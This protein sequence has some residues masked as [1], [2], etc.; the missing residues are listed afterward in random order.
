MSMKSWSEVGFGFPLW[1]KDN[2]EKIKNFI[3][4]NLELIYDEKNDADETRKRF[5]E[6][7]EEEDEDNYGI[8]YLMF[9]ILDEFASETI[10]RIIEK[11]EGE[12][13]FIRGFQPCGDTDTEEHLGVEPI[14][15]WSIKEPVTKEEVIEMLNK[16]ANILGITEEPDFFDLEYFG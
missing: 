10:A 2:N 6:F 16:Y 13:F 12:K 3:L 11:K 4:D 1:N 7:S 5:K 14:Y 15:A 8:E 9:D